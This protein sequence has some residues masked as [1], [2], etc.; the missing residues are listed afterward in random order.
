MDTGHTGCHQLFA[1]ADAPFDAYLTG[2][3][4]GLALQ[5]FL[6]QLFRK[7]YL[8]GFRHHIQL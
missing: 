7:V 2:F 6:G 5:C 1:L 3:L 8:E 4:I